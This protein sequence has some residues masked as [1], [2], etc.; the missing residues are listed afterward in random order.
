LSQKEKKQPSIFKPKKE[1]M[2]VK[3]M[4]VYRKQAYLIAKLSPSTKNA[5]NQTKTVSIGCMQLFVIVLLS[6]C[7]PSLELS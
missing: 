2:S 3:G 5:S 7:R 6:H 1:E 4:V